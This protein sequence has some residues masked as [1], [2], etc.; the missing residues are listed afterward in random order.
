MSGYRRWLIMA[1]AIIFPVLV[2]LFLTLS[3]GSVAFCT[4]EGHWHRMTPP[5]QGTTPI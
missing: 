2:A 3:D 1:A 4:Q 5:G